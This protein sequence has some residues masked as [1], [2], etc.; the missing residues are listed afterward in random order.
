MYTWC[1]YLFFVQGLGARSYLNKCAIQDSW[2]AMDGGWSRWLDSLLEIIPSGTIRINVKRK[3][4]FLLR[5]HI[6]LVL[7]YAPG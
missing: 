7:G 2:Y 5:E 1:I 4:R 6:V 3:H